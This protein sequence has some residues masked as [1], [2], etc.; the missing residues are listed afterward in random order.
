MAGVGVCALRLRT[1][2]NRNKSAGKA[3]R[4]DSRND[5]ALKE[6]KKYELVMDLLHLA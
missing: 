1:M 6:D 5:R 3:R 2:G 4:R